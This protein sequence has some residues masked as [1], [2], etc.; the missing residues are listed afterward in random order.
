MDFTEELV[1]LEVN[2]FFNVQHDVFQC[3]NEIQKKRKVR[4]KKHLFKKYHID[5]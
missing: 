5:Y 4:V 3:I 1:E 2:L